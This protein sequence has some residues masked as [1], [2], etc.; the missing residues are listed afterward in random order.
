MLSLRLTLWASLTLVTLLIWSS[1]GVLVVGGRNHH[2]QAH[3]HA[4][5][6]SSHH[7][8]HHHHRNNLPV[9]DPIIED[10]TPAEIDL[11]SFAKDDDDDTDE[12]TGGVQLL[13]EQESPILEPAGIESKSYRLG[14]PVEQQAGDTDLDTRHGHATSDLIKGSSPNA[15]AD[16]DTELE[17]SGRLMAGGCPHGC[18]KHQIC[19]VSAMGGRCVKKHPIRE[20]G[21][22][23]QGQIG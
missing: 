17:S 1:S 9:V 11:S 12:E 8:H 4:P 15:L 2:A 5:K 16:T 6:P 18:A 7:H 14:L 22:G 19:V 21:T 3:H 23:L 10:S 20:G 13:A